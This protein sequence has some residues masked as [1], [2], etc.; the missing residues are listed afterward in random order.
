MKKAEQP[1]VET[2]TET[3]TLVLAEAPEL[4]ALEP[5]RAAIIV[6]TFGPMSEKV[7]EFE[8]QFN[9]LIQE[10]ESGIDLALTKKAKRLR[11]DISKVRTE[12]EKLRKDQ[13]EE[14]LRFGKAI[15]GAANVL[16]W[17]VVAKENRLK[18]IEDHF[19][20]LERERLEKL[21][22][23]RV[24]LLSPYVDDAEMR[25]LSSMDEDVWE[26]YLSTKKKDYEDRIAAE[27]AAQKAREAEAKKQEVYRERKDTI[28]PMLIYR[29]GEDVPPAM[30]LNADT[31]EAQFKKIKKWYEDGKAA[32]DARQEAVRKEQEESARVAKEAQEKADRIE[33]RSTEMAPYMS[34]IENFSEMLDM[35]QEV[36]EQELEAAK[37]NQG[38]ASVEAS[39]LSEIYIKSRRAGFQ[40]LPEVVDATGIEFL[41]TDEEKWKALRDDLDALKTKYDFEDAAFSKKSRGVGKLIDKI[42]T[43]MDE[44]TAKM[45]EK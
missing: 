23:E 25:D 39:G 11:L 26:S 37:K 9:A 24:E 44:T 12:T 6:N 10:S 19:E 13:K 18:E 8:D 34:V 2:T 15:D 27:E 3:T 29:Q 22:T 28:L 42:T 33:K 4:L 41:Q 32:Y 16:K 45:N 1:V 17:A 43:W 40:A 21:Q 5:S 38:Q 14:S 20:T 7:A 36:Y 30:E 31:T 35:E